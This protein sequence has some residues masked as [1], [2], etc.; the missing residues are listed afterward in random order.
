MTSA[1]F[2]GSDGLSQPKPRTV[3]LNWYLTG[4]VPVVVTAISVQG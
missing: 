4:D 2:V 3:A 1:R